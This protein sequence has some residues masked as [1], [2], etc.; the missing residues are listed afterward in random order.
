MSQ[1]DP[2]APLSQILAALAAGE[3]GHVAGAYLTGSAATGA[4]TPSSD[5]DLLVVTE[6]SLLAEDRSELLTRLLTA[7][8]WSGHRESHPDAADRRPLEVTVLVRPAS[9]S[10]LETPLVDFQ[11]GEW[12]RSEYLAGVVPEPVADPDSVLLVATA[13]AQ[14]RVLLGAPLA[15]LLPEPT[16]EQTRQAIVTCVPDV[17]AGLV[18]DERNTL[19]TL[20]RMIVT[21]G[22][23]QIVSKDAAART[24]AE[25]LTPDDAELMI[26]ARA[27]YLGTSAPL[28]STLMPRV[29]QLADALARIA[30]ET[31]AEHPPRS[32]SAVVD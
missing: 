15:Q 32:G 27:D 26:L 13:Y 29:A 5:I 24:L 21:L 14:H 6:R 1:A 31:A 17:L 25:R 2:V 7:S 30:R 20:A 4:L 3:F 9:P 16:R 12:N 23:G 28:W 22:T 18:G 8:G 10:W 19:L 11:F